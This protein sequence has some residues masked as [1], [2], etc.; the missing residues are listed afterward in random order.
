[1]TGGIGDLES[2]VP[3]RLQG[4]PPASCRRVRGKGETGRLENQ[5]VTDAARRRRD[6]YAGYLIRWSRFW[7]R[8]IPAG[9]QVDPEV[10]E[11]YLRKDSSRAL[12][13]RSH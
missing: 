13:Q 4:A 10:I 9:T 12:E 7:S 2:L 11:A 5:P 3:S 6:A 1:V 8:P